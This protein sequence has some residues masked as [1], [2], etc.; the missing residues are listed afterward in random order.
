MAKADLE[1]IKKIL[2]RN[3]IEIRKVS[4][5]ITDLQNELDAQVEEKAPPVKKQF[6]I[7]VSDPNGHLVDQD[8]VGWVLQMPEDADSRFC[9]EHLC[10]AAYEYNTTPKGRRLPVQT[11]GE[12]CEVLT[13]KFT[14]EHSVWIKTKEPLYVNRTSNEIPKVEDKL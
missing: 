13:S 10:Q 14:K 6:V 1:L 11:I 8:L 5:I 4:Q 7:L 12:A 2:Q 9:E 3:E